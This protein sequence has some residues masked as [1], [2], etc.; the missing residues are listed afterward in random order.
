[1]KGEENRYRK[2]GEVE[3]V[4][5]KCELLCRTVPTSEQSSTSF[6]ITFKLPC[7]LTILVKLSDSE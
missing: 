6:L 1:M 5:K 7:N 2:Y 4:E 3:N